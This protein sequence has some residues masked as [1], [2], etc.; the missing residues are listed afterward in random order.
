MHIVLSDNRVFFV[1]M[2]TVENIKDLM[3]GAPYFWAD[4][5]LVI[6][7]LSKDTIRR[8]IE[9]IVENEYIDLILSQIGVVQDIYGVDYTFENI[10][11]AWDA[12]L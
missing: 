6:S 11:D 10:K 9:H 8:S 5:M 7:D 1:T 4:S 2:F 12:S 3:K